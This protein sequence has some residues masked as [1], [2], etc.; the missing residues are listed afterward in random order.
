MRREANENCLFV[1][2]TDVAY[3]GRREFLILQNFYEFAKWLYL[4]NYHN[5]K[6][7]PTNPYQIIKS[8]VGSIRFNWLKYPSKVFGKQL[9]RK[10][11]AF[12]MQKLIK[13]ILMKL[14]LYL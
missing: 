12:K 2:M 11:D 6:Y 14:I 9:T 4:N 8:D 1:W 10:I 5:I 13:K 7:I 3:S